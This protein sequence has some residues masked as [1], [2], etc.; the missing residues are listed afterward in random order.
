MAEVISRPVLPAT[1]VSGFWNITSK[2]SPEAYRAWLSNALRLNAG[3]VFFYEDESVLRLVSDIRAGLQTVF[4]KLAIRDF[5]VAR[6]YDRAWVDQFHIPT[7]ELG[8]IWLEKVFMMEKAAALNPFGSQWFAWMDAGCAPYRQR[9][10]GPEPWPSEQALARLPRDRVVHT[11]V[12]EW[13][14]HFSGTAYMYHAAMAAPVRQRFEQE[15]RRCA[16][17]RNPLPC[18]EDQYV[19]TQLLDRE[20][21]AFHKVGDGYGE[22]MPLLANA[23]TA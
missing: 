3:M 10:P 22:L 2:Y 7:A 6:L 8:M 16:A 5:A 9:A 12:E 23:P 14:H 13:Y 21:A 1:V 15:V 19:W 20:P 18:G 4:V 11:H 17:S